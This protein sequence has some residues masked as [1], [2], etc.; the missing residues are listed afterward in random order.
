MHDYEQQA[1]FEQCICFLTEMI[2]KY[3]EQVEFLEPPN[4]TNKEQG[5]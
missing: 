5:Q 2:E 3:A 1:A 4:S